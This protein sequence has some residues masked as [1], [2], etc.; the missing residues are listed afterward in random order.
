MEYNIRELN[1]SDYNNYLEL[2]ND[3]RTTYFSEQ[4]FINILD[5]LHNIKIYVIEKDSK[6][7]AS[8]TLNIEQKFIHNCGKL[9]HVEDVCVKKEFRNSGY[10]KIIIN[11]LIEEAKNM[12]C[13]KITLY[14]SE[15]NSNFYKKYGFEI[16]GNQMS[17]LLD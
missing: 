14:C 12:K 15:N 2:I 9:A 11:K 5:N 17:Q 4:D 13:Y 10:G 3:F 16:T 1:C 7:V 6:L 8:A